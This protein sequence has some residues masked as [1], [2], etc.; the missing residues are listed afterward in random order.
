IAAALVATVGVAAR[1][2]WMGARSR[3]G[4]PK[5]AA[6]FGVRVR[7]DEEF[8]N[9]G[10]NLIALSPDGK[11]LAYIANGRLNVRPLDRLE[12]TPIRGTEFAANNVATIRS[13]FFSPNGQWIGFLQGGQIKKVSING[14]TPVP[15]VPA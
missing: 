9:L 13:P 1:G 10:G 3:P 15:I 11:Y 5:L 12:S 2:G 14:G 4:E 8:S 6:R 7:A